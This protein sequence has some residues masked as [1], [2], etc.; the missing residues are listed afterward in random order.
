LPDEEARELQ[1]QADRLE[2]M[3]VYE[4]M[5]EEIEA[6][7]EVLDVHRS[8]FE[9]MMADP[10]SAMDRAYHLFSE[11]P[12]APLRYTA[13]DLERA[14]G[15]VGY[16]SWAGDELG[17]EFME[18]AFAVT[19]RLAGDKEQRSRLARRLLMAMPEYVDAGRY[20][21]A[22]LIQYSAF[23]LTEVPEE[24]NPF[25]F[26]MFQLAYEEWVRQ[27]EDERDAL[28]KE[29]GIDRSALGKGSIADVFT[30]ARDIMKDPE[31]R[32]RIE[33]F[34]ATHRAE[35]EQTEAWAMRLE[36][37]AANLLERDDAGCMLLTLEEMSPWL[38]VLMERVE[39]MIER[40]Q[41][42]VSTG[43]TPD[44]AIQKEVRDALVAT[45]E[46]M[47]PEI[48]TRERVD[49]L[50][51]DLQ[52]YRRRLMEAGEEEAVRWAD[53]AL[54]AVH[55]EGPPAENPFLMVT[56]YASLR[57]AMEKAAENS[58]RARERADSGDE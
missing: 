20:R 50:V 42:A 25:M 43:Q 4:M 55:R 45:I 54:I 49:Q 57:A 15:A 56:C 19:V 32:A 29:L 12:F 1:E 7:G 52:D 26:V 11:E 44:A 35:H 58:A 51:G 38:P 5:H 53:G 39:P 8:E 34:Y 18:T 33:A 3:A 6:A 48:Y 37:E 24:S 16:P 31:K 13:D 40:A 47:V 46:E 36:S 27:K 30:V 23:R 2:D 14:F 10:A 17:D 41:E 21:D 22:W 28:L 9:E